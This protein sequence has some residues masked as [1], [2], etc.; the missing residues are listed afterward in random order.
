M[1]TIIDRGQRTLKNIFR[2]ISVAAVSLILQACFGILPPDPIICEYGVPTP[3]ENQETVI[4]GTVMSR[5]TG[6]PIFGIMV[7]VEGT[8]VSARTNED[9]YFFLRATIRNSY[10]IK[11]EDVDGPYNGGLFKRETW[12]LKQEDTYNTLLIGMDLDTESNAEPNTP[13][14]EP[15]TKPA[16]EPETKPGAEPETKPCCTEPGTKPGTEPETEP[17]T[18]PDTGTETEPD[19]EPGTQPGTGTET[20]PGTGTETKPG[21]RPETKPGTKPE[22]KPGTKPGKN[23]GTKPG[24][25]TATPQ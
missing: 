22:T 5:K 19:T 13:A 24:T 15:E 9:G 3:Y 11:L 1:K 23:P 8:G 10:T 25:D 16:T 14:T 2:A 7:S 18:E 17:G 20:Q 4:H 6:E 12:R 21:T